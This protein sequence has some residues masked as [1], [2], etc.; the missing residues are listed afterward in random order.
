ML[1]VR[2]RRRARTGVDTWHIRQIH[3]LNSLNSDLLRRIW[4]MVAMAAAQLKAN[5]DFKS[6]RLEAQGRPTPHRVKG[7]QRY[8]A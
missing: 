7:R 6:R 3:P 5:N 1:V 4:D 8:D 2:A